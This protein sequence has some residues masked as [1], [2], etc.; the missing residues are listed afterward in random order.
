MW[1]YPTNHYNMEE[2]RQTHIDLE[3]LKVKVV[4]MEKKFDDTIKTLEKKFDTNLGGFFKVFCLTIAALALIAGGMFTILRSDIKE[5]GS[6]VSRIRQIRQPS[7]SPQLPFK[8][9]DKGER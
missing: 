3:V 9:Y 8:P 4:D 2:R 6:T 5:I 1:S 7:P